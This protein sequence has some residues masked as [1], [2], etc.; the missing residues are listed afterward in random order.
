MTV[1]Y[2]FGRIHHGHMYFGG[3]RTII[4]F[5]LSTLFFWDVMTFL[6]QARYIQRIY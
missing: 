1:K 2:R 5:E 3:Q 6:L 4:V